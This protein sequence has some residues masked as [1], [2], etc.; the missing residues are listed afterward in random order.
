MLTKIASRKRAQREFPKPS[1]CERCGSGVLV[2][3]HHPDHQD[4]LS[5]IFLCQACH[6]EEETARGTW[7]H[8]RRKV[9]KCALCG[10]EFS[11]YTHSRVK[12]CSDSCRRKVGRINAHKRWG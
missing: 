4:A 11:N 8:G 9:K 12:L 7:G 2:Q 1:P 6:A 5:V 10:A 3:R